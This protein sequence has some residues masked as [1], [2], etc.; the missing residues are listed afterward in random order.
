[1]QVKH[2]GMHT[3]YCCYLT[4]QL[5][6]CKA[7][8]KGMIEMDYK[9][10]LKLD[11][12]QVDSLVLSALKDSYEECIK[13]IAS[14]ERQKW[15]PLEDVM[16]RHEALLEVIRYYSVPTEYKKYVKYWDQ[17]LKQTLKETVQKVKKTDEKTK[18]NGD[19]S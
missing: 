16:D 6:S 8:I 19:G 17:Y 2:G 4:L 12:D 5:P 3:A 15:D 13:T 1:M 18:G 9:F 7:T 11:G 14:P 10:T